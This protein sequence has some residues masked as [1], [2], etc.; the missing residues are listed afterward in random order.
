MSG[1]LIVLVIFFVLSK[2]KEK[3]KQPHSSFSFLFTSTEVITTGPPGKSLIQE[4]LNEHVSAQCQAHTHLLVSL[5]MSYKVT[6]C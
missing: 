5:F 2:G 4:L 1:L 3:K 6:L